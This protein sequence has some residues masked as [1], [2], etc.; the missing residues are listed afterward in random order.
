MFELIYYGLVKWW[1]ER[2]FYAGRSYW[3]ENELGRNWRI[4]NIRWQ[5]GK[6]YGE[7][8]RTERRFL[9]SEERKSK[10]EAE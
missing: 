7:M 10:Q 4:P 8:F 6:I 9:E 1:V 2:D 5:N 3:V